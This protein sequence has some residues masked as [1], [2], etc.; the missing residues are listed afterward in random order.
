M[1]A[2]I[3]LF[4]PES[5]MDMMDLSREQGG[6]KSLG[7]SPWHRMG[8]LF[9]EWLCMNWAKVEMQRVSWHRLHQKVLRG[10]LYQGL[11]DAV[12][13]GNHDPQPSIHLDPLDILHDCS[14]G[15]LRG[16]SRRGS[17]FCLRVQ[18]RIHSMQETMLRYKFSLFFPFDLNLS[19][20]L[21]ALS[22]H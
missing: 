10:D 5:M 18:I 9:E 3:V 6:E 14:R 20:F 8:T 11:Q 12:S 1:L 4:Y 22:C 16:T 2:L 7:L 13:S 21:F 15:D 17:C 19:F